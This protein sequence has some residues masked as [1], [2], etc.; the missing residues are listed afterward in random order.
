MQQLTV[1]QYAKKIKVSR[2]TVY[3]MIESKSLP[4]GAKAKKIAGRVIVQ[5][6]DSVSPQ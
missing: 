4:D 3:R 6:K 5:V 1:A 2:W